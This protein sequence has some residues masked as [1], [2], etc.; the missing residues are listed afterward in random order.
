MGFKHCNPFLSVQKAKDTPKWQVKDIRLQQNIAHVSLSL[1][2]GSAS[3]RN[4]SRPAFQELPSE[5]SGPNK[6]LLVTHCG[7]SS[8]V[9]LIMLSAYSHQQTQTHISESLSCFDHAHFPRPV[10][11]L[12]WT[13]HCLDEPRPSASRVTVGKGRLQSQLASQRTI[14]TDQAC[15][16]GEN[17]PGPESTRRIFSNTTIWTMGGWKKKVWRRRKKRKLNLSTPKIFALL[18][19]T[20]VIWFRFS[21]IF[22]DTLLR[23]DRRELWSRHIISLWQENYWMKCECL[24]CRPAGG[25]LRN[26]HEINWLRAGSEVNT[27]QA[28]DTGKIYLW[29]MKGHLS[30]FPSKHWFCLFCKLPVGHP[31]LCESEPIKWKRNKNTPCQTDSLLAESKAKE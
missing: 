30:K 5:I 13:C 28:Q 31:T 7:G 3:D 4:V 29:L 22:G 26:W 8:P 14:K 17:F 12:Q 6:C 27:C 10:S 11:P 20:K 2:F 1:S 25:V 15:R 23:G 16:S 24:Y 21:S 18:R 19:K 9:E